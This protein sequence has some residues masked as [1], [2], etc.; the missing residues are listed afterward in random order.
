MNNDVGDV[1]NKKD[2]KNATEIR[3][4]APMVFV[5]AFV[6]I[7]GAVFFA[8]AEEDEFHQPLGNGECTSD[9]GLSYD[10]VNNGTGKRV[11]SIADTTF[12]VYF[13][14]YGGHPGSPAVPLTK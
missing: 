8:L 12:G 2:T 1:K 6:M 4:I 10:N 7:A 9:D 11:N 13:N 3:T 5:A 14:S